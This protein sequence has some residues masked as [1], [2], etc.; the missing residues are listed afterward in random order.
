MT[1]SSRRETRTGDPH[2]QLFKLRPATQQLQ[3]AGPADCF[4]MLVKSAHR[5][6]PRHWHSRAVGPRA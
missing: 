5:A 6:R 4:L 1:R 2:W 3:A